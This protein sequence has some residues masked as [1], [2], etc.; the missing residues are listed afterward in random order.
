MADEQ[1]G[2]LLA[3]GFY[4]LLRLR[5]IRTLLVANP[6]AGAEIVALVPGGVS[7]EVL[8]LR[9]T[10]TTSAAVANRLPV[11]QL[12]DTDGK[13]AYEFPGAAVQAASLAVSYSW[14]AGY[15]TSTAVSGQQ[16]PM[17]APAPVVLA[18]GVVRTVTTLLDVA[19]QWSAVVLTVREW[20]P[21][22]VQQQADWIGR[23]LLTVE[24]S[25]EGS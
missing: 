2:M 19:D 23:Q 1:T 12:R 16:L 4:E 11:L 6:A 10:L 20:S 14:S 9:A 18:G 21:A 8:A 15:G 17:P 3:R 24:L 22:Q 13:V 7:W 25:T 5:L